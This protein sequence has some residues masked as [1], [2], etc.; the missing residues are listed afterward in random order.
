MCEKGDK[1]KKKKKKY[2]KLI[3]FGMLQVELKG[4]SESK[5]VAWITLALGYL[6]LHISYHFH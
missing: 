5:Q 6:S 1:K 3:T 2:C 4:A